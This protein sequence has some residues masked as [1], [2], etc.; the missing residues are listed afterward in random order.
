MNTAE[1]V[2]QLELKVNTGGLGSVVLYSKIIPTVTDSTM[3]GFCLVRKD[4]MYDIQIVELGE[5]A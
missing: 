2:G 3:I 1:M 5:V 4:G